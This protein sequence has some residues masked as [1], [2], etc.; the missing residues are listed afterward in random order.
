MMKAVFR[1]KREGLCVRGVNPILYADYPDPDVIRAG[2]AWY[3]IS[4]TMHMFPG[5]QILRSYDLMHWEH[6]AYV[7]DRLDDTPAQR[8]EN[9]NIYGKGMWAASLR[10]HDGVFHVLFTSNDMQKSCHYTAAR[11][12]GPW[13]RHEIAGFYYDPSILFD[14]DGRVYIASGNREIRVTEMESDLSGPK[15]NGLNRV[16]FRDDTEGLGWEGSHFYK[17]DG[18]Y[19]LFNIHWPRGGLRAMGCHAAEKLTDDFTGGPFMELDFQGRHAGVAQGGPVQLPD[20][21]WALF[22]FQDHGAVGR[23]PVLVPM[24]WEQGMPKVDTVPETLELPSFRPDYVYAP[25][26]ASDA[27][28]GGL[29]P[30]WQWNHVPDAAHY[31]I[32]EE[33]LRLTAGRTAKTLEDA[34][35][36]LTQRC[37]GPQ[38]RMEVTVTGSDM[39]P[40]D[41]AGLCALQGRHGEIALV[42]EEKGFALAMKAKEADGLRAR[43]PWPEDRARLQ[44]QFDF[45][46]DEA[47][48]FY[49]DGAWTLLG[50]VHPLV[51]ALDHFMGCRVGLFL[52]AKDAPGGSA[53]FSDFV[54]S[55][56]TDR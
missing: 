13:T 56:A 26:Y 48:F 11:P 34:P 25:L 20:G 41:C 4:T 7:F 47:A 33:G 12:E 35:N 49:W 31:R 44:V 28:R 38:C 16:V 53:V 39:R 5:G 30:L 27:L 10:Y 15:P 18:R 54:Y 45:D 6:C 29:S 9:G 3:M 19:Y 51:Y 43:V 36:T 50:G 21:R 32:T 1:K 17:I 42:R 14:D 40:G 8:L 46:R 24:T 22:L 23:I 37:F 2:D 52:Y 55:A